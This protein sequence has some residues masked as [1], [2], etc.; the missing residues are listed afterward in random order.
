MN[1]IVIK[2]NGEYGVEDIFFYV[3]S[4]YREVSGIKDKSFNIVKKF[5][6]ELGTIVIVK[7]VWNDY[8]FEVSGGSKV[9]KLLKEKE[10][11]RRQRIKR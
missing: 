8:W 2:H 4:A 10:N 5:N 11:E 3:V 6:D 9:S 1:R 7:K